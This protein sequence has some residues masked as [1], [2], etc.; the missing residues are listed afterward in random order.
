MGLVPISFAST[1]KSGSR[2]ALTSEA[3]TCTYGVVVHG[4]SRPHFLRNPKSLVEA[5]K[6]CCLRDER[7]FETAHVV[8]AECWLLRTYCQCQSGGRRSGKTATQIGEEVRVSF[9]IDK[10]NGVIPRIGR[11][12]QGQYHRQ[13]LSSFERHAVNEELASIRATSENVR[14]G[15]E[16]K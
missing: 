6:V 4:Q 16:I 7:R 10:P 11:Y 3:C 8:N 2:A 14:V 5:I 13:I 9:K 15:D 12:R 1:R